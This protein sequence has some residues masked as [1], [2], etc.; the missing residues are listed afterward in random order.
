MEPATLS[1]ALV[2]ANGVSETAVLNTTY[3][4]FNLRQGRHHLWTKT[5]TPYTVCKTWKCGQPREPTENALFSP[6]VSSFAG[7]ANPCRKCDG[8]PASKT[9]SLQTPGV[10]DARLGATQFAVEGAPSEAE[11][12]QVS[13]IN[14]E[15]ASEG[16]SSN[17]SLEGDNGR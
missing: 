7:L 14:N 10:E 15:S 11:L 3:A 2:V 9:V 12:L 1:N 16:E 6:L 8:N 4:V 17:A 5:F 13:I